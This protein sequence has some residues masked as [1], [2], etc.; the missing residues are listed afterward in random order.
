MSTED[1]APRPDV[2]HEDPELPNP[3]EPKQTGLIA[4]FAN[5]SVAANLMMIFIIIMGVFSYFTIQRQ[6]FPNIEIN[7]INISAVYRG[8]S[9]QEIEESILIKIEESLKDITEIKKATSRAFRGSGRVTL[10]IQENKELTDVLDK[11]KARVDSIATFPADMEP[12]DIS[13]IEFQ[14]DVIEMSLVGD[15]PITQLK[16]IAKKIEDELL[17]LSNISLVSVDAPEDEIA[18]EI[19]PDVLRKY[20]LT[21]G[22]VQLAIQNYSANISAGELRTD[23]GIV[24]VRVENQMYNGDEFRRIPIKISETGAKVYLGDVATIEDGFEEGLGNAGPPCVL[25]RRHH[26]DAGFWCHD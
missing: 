7:Y 6:M 8:A 12:P 15:L 14:Q 23:S 21:L 10:E 4:F 24:A 18:I 1:S 3:F 16:P 11:V 20:N 26:D 13:Q 17:Q 9:P 2:P 22:D 25:L 5:N 19:Q